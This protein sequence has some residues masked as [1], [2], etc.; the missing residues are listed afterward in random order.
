MTCSAHFGI[1]VFVEAVNA[2]LDL[3]D[4]GRETVNQIVVPKDAIGKDGG[5]E[6]LMMGMLEDVLKVGIH[7]RFTT[8]EGDIFSA[9]LVEVGQDAAPFLLRQFVGEG[10]AGTHETMLATEVAGIGEVAGE[11]MGDIGN[12]RL[13]NMVGQSKRAGCDGCKELLELCELLLG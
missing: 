7:E 13:R 5:G 4:E 3:A 8:S 10:F 11:L 12:L 6:T 1:G 9:L 2:Y